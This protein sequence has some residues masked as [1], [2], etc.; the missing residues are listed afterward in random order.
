MWKAK[1]RVIPLVWD[2]SKDQEE[3]KRFIPGKN[4]LLNSKRRIFLSVEVFFYFPNLK[5]VK[6]INKKKTVKTSF[7]VNA[8]Q[9]LAPGQI[10]VIV[11]CSKVE[12]FKILINYSTGNLNWRMR[13]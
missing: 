1:I 5:T 7:L 13:L 12:C 2:K 4:S 9:N 11:F 3:L 6:Y 8:I 10:L